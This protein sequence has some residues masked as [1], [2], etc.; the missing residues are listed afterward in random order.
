[1]DFKEKT[2]RQIR[3]WAWAASVLPIAGLAG[4]FFIWAFG[5]KET[6]SLALVIGETIMFTVAVVWWWW[7]LMV[8]RNI[9]KQWDF[10]RETVNEVSKDI[11]EIKHEVRSVFSKKNLKDK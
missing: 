11:K 7:A 2:I 6:L 9:I 10:T 1:M 3:W 8:V 5:T 4:I